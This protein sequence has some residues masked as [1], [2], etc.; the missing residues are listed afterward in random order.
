MRQ[1]CPLSLG[2]RGGVRVVGCAVLPPLPGGEGW[3]E[4]LRGRT[5]F[6]W[7]AHALSPNPSPPGGGEL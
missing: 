4:G 6:G 1:F 2:E 5:K 3:G 7:N